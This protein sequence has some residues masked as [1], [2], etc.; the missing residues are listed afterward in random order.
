M[1]F[2]PYMSDFGGKCREAFDFYA[3]ALGGQVV[4]RTTY[5]ESPVCERMPPGSAGLVMHSCLVAGDA[6]IMGADG[7]PASRS[8]DEGTAINIS[9]DST[10]DAERIWA[11]LSVGADIRMPLQETPWAHRWGML[12]DRFGKPW[13]VNHLKAGEDCPP[14]GHA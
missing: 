2:I 10:A 6:V 7:P 4:G 11:A 1:Q 12:V 13:M 9:V 8:G 3:L 5:G 14:H